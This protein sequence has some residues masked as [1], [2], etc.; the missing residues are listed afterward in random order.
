MK[1]L[2]LTLF[3]APALAHADLIYK[4]KSVNFNDQLSANLR[5]DEDGKGGHLELSYWSGYPPITLVYADLKAPKLIRGKKSFASE[6][7]PL[8]GRSAEVLVPAD[9][10]E[11]DFFVAGLIQSKEGLKA[12]ASEMNCNRF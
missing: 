10:L 6:V 9:F 12:P 11:Q 8:W 5:F 2:L 7:D 3:L 1:L 4:C